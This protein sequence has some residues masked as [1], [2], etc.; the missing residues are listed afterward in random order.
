M[1]W[2]QIWTSIK[3]FFTNNF[4]DI[5]VFFAVLVI[6]IVVVKIILNLVKK[7]MSKTKIEKETIK[8]KKI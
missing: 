1:N 8:N 3:D 2:N 5:V 7:L 6:G 4:W